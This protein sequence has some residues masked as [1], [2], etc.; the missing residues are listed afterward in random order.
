MRKVMLVLFMMFL[1]MQWSTAAVAQY[2]AHETDRAAQKHLG[3]HAHEHEDHATDRTDEG[4]DKTFDADC[5][6]CIAHGAHVIGAP[7]SPLASADAVLE[8]I[9]YLAFVPEPLPRDLFRPPLSH[10]A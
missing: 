8:P 7:A 3:H 4:N 1:P 6:T 2:C 5:P 10:L 9:F